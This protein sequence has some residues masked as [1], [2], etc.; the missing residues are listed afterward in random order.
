MTCDDV[1]TDGMMMQSTIRWERTIWWYNVK[2]V[3]Q[4][5]TQQYDG[6]M[7]QR[8]N[9]RYDNAIDDTTGCCNGR[10]VIQWETMWRTIWWCVWQRGWQSMMMEVKA[11]LSFICQ[12]QS[13]L[14]YMTQ[15]LTAMQ[16]LQCCR[17]CMQSLQC[18]CDCMQ[19]HAMLLQSLWKKTLCLR[20]S[21]FLKIH[22][23][24]EAGLKVCPKCFFTT[25]VNRFISLFICLF[26]KRRNEKRDSFYTA[27]VFLPAPNTIVRDKKFVFCKFLK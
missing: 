4:W 20:L 11:N 23:E 27:N 8:N 16:S 1:T 9:G 26:Q 17:G 7:W 12:N 5:H 25:T 22:R 6:T 14:L 18:H 15:L 24:Q 10:T 3:L 2:P 19:L 13:S 21:E